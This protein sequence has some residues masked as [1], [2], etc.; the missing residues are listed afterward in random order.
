M[1][2][3]LFGL[4][5]GLLGNAAVFADEK[6]PPIVVGAIVPLSGDFGALGQSTLNA[7]KLASKQP[8][9][10]PV[11]LLQE[12]NRSCQSADAVSA[13]HKLVAVNSAQVIITLCTGAAEG[14]L[15]L[16]KSRRLPLIQLSESGVD[17]ENY[18]LKLMPDGIGFMEVL[19]DEFARRYKKM[20]IIG[21]EQPV[22]SGERGNLTV[23]ERMFT[24]KGGKIVYRETFPGSV[25]DLRSL[26]EK[27]RQSGAEAVSPFIGSAAQMA[28]FMKQADELH[29][30]E[31]VHLA[32]NFAFEFLYD[33]LL[34]V[35]PKLAS[36][37]GL[38]SS[39][40]KATTSSSFIEQYRNEFG[41]APKQ[42]ADYAFD[43]V[44]IIRRCGTDQ[45]CYRKTSLGVSGPIQFDRAG[46]RQAPFVLKRL[47]NGLFQEVEKGGL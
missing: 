3:L 44:A 9:G 31:S 6:G 25:T 46:R 27:I 38:E 36:L 13:F 5:I 43:A 26:I 41:E 47:H 1:R 23:F 21:D 35:Y 2:Y 34:A 37:E 8:E 40:L 42:F 17:P 18:M 15:P 22:N 20:A 39:N 12:D 14:V 4:C 24:E 45:S 30:W 29:L 11:R 33:A 16:A 10:R 19:T 28:L 7:M 32:G